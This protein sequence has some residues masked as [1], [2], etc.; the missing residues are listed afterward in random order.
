MLVCDRCL[1][2]QH[3]LC[4]GLT[5]VPPDEF[6]YCQKCLDEIEQ[7]NER[8]VCFD[9]ALMTYLQYGKLPES[10]LEQ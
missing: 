4:A 1:G 8:D 2:V 10:E 3:L 6:W 9:N 5:E 7:L